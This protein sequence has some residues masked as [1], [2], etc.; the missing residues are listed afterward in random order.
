MNAKKNPKT[1]HEF[2][3][4]RFWCKKEIHDER[5][6]GGMDLDESNFEESEL[7]SVFNVYF[8]TIDLEM[9]YRSNLDMIHVRY[10]T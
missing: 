10:F 1:F 7:S 3:F 2:V 8:A 9:I 4:N 6:A 5:Y